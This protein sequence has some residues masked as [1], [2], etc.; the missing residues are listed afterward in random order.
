M[1]L[2]LWAV[3]SVGALATVVLGAAVPRAYPAAAAATS[4]R[5][6]TVS[7]D[8]QAMV[9]P[10]VAFVSVG[11][12][13]NALEASKAQGMT[14]TIVAEA[15]TKI[16]ALGIPDRDIQTEGISLDPQY[17][18]RGT[19]TGFQA[20]DTLS[21]VVEHPAAAGSVI[22]AGVAAGANHNISINFGLKDDTTART[23]ALKAA[24][25]IAQRKAIAVAA[26]LGISLQGA[27]IQVV[28]NVSQPVTF[29]GR[30]AIAP[31]AISAPTP[32]QTG[33]LIVSDNVTVT[34]T[35]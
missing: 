14:N 17:D 20:T 30:E 5:S 1:T 19:L 6:I 7:A 13:Q 27:K 32:I 23:E 8:G 9:T 21:I 2:R 29:T 22:D 26:Q 25:S 24:V 28:E 12:Q 4:D 3:L 35:L 18:D 34:Y 33:T 10:D 16:K 15:L 11:V 31:S